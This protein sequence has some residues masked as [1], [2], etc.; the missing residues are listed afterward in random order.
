MLHKSVRKTY[1]FGCFEEI[2]GLSRRQQS[3]PSSDGGNLTVSV[4]KNC[5]LFEDVESEGKAG[6]SKFGTYFMKMEIDNL[7]SIQIQS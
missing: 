1:C 7:R 4:P 5:A 6:N 2:V 3:G